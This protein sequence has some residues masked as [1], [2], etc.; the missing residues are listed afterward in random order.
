M[1]PFDRKIRD[2]DQHVAHITLWI[3]RK[4]Y[5]FAGT[6]RGHRQIRGIAARVL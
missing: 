4:N 5:L 2:V 3:G 6:D 1:N